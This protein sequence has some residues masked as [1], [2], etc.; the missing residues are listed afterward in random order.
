MH[1]LLIT[2]QKIP[3]RSRILQIRLRVPLLRM[4]KGRKLDAISDEEYGRVISNHIPISLISIKLDGES[5][6]IP[7]S[8]GRAL[9]AA[10]GGET[11][12]NFGLLADAIEDGCRCD[13]GYVVG[14]FEFSKRAGSF[15]MDDSF[16]NSFTIKVGK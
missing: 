11:N 13:V 7:R 10:D 14:H 1:R 8:I 4:D 6:R 15:S 5:T 2:R 3:K 12:S 9:F 16:R